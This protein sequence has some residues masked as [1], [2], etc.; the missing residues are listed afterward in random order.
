MS[1]APE[2]PA[3]AEAAAVGAAALKGAASKVA[4]LPDGMEDEAKLLL[5]FAEVRGV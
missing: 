3:P 4:E 1:R 5:A 2:P